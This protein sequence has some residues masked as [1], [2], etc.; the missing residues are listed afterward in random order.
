VVSMAVVIAVGVN[1]DGQR[2]VLGLDV[3]PRSYASGVTDVPV[4]LVTGPVGVG[5]TSVAFE[6]SELLEEAGVPHAVVDVDTL[7]WCY[8]APPGDPFRVNL[9]MQNLAAIWPN[10]QAQ[11]AKR[12]LLVDV[13]E[14]R[15]QLTRIV[16]A[17][18]GAEILIIRLRATLETLVTRVRQRETGLARDRLIQR[19]VEL[20]ASMERAAVEHI[21][22]DTDGRTVL[23]VAQDVLVRTG[24]RASRCR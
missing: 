15:D 6:V 5:K 17:V 20:A 23:E 16:A 13:I 12:L 21:V 7:R 11:G 3:G 22:V 2:E 1:Q 24:W 4:L 18:P 10:F 19:A 14:S 8:P 9:A